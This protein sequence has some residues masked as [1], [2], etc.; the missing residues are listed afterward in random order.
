MLQVDLNEAVTGD[1]ISCCL[2]GVIRK[3]VIKL[4]EYIIVTTVGQAVERSSFALHYFITVYS[5]SELNV[6][7]AMTV[8]CPRVF[9]IFTSYTTA[10]K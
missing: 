5:S 8:F 4:Q 2:E 1:F 9:F 7:L 10:L 6:Q 3:N